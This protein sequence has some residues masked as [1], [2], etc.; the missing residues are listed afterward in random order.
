M[1]KIL[2]MLLCLVLMLSCASSLSEG[3]YQAVL[4]DKAGLLS[5]EEAEKVAAAM[6]PITEFGHAGFLT[7]DGS[8][9]TDV[10][11]KA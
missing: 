10:L 7:Y 4:D 6:E 9:S 11:G 1:R 8:D 3:M 2:S 5:A